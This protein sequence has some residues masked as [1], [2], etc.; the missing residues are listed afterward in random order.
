MCLITGVIILIIGNNGFTSAGNLDCISDNNTSCSLSGIIMYVGGSGPGNYS[1]IQDAIDDASDG[2]TVFVYD[3]SSPYYENIIIEKSLVL[4][5]ENRNT[6]IIDG[7][8]NEGYVLRIEADY[9]EVSGFTIIN[10]GNAIEMWSN[11]SSINDNVITNNLWTGI[12]LY[13]SRDTII[14]KN[15]ITNNS[16][17][18]IDLLGCSNNIIM[19]NEIT[20]HNWE[21]INLEYSICNNI[22]RNVIS[23]NTDNI[24]FHFFSSGNI[25]RKNIIS[26]SRD[27]GIQIMYGSD[28]NTICSNTL[29]NNEYCGLQLDT[30]GN[31]VCCNNFINNKARHVTFARIT[32]VTTI[33]NFNKWYGNYWDNWIGLEQPSYSRFPK[34]IVGHLTRGI[35]KIPSFAFDWHPAKE[36]Y[37][38]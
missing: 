35:P 8:W 27:W 25:I 19:E 14:F 10:S 21:G 26:N 36:P 2:D 33:I 17:R 7:N 22:S 16:G 37:D 9:V 38:I 24:N 5:G 6:T 12:F 18:G 30:S 15:N 13:K 34:I 20:K 11:H 23:D 29:A 4:K 1:S 31:I 3:D 28:N 32:L